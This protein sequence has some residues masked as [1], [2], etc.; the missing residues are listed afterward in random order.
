MINSYIDANTA[1]VIAD[2]VNSYDHYTKVF[3]DRI[4]RMAAAGQYRDLISLDE[5]WYSGVDWDRVI[6]ELESL[7]FTIKLE[8]GRNPGARKSIERYWKH[9]IITW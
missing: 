1:K 6:E 4:C 5:G 7:G 9:Y 3:L 2:K 8:E